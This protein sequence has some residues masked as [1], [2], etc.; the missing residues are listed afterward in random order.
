MF[1]VRKAEIED[2]PAVAEIHVNTWKYSYKGIIDDSLLDKLSYENSAKNNAKLLEVKNIYIFVACFN[3]QIVGFIV[4]ST[5]SRDAIFKEYA[6][7]FGLYILPDY[8]RQGI[9]KLLFNKAVE[10]FKINR[11]RAFMLWAL[12]DNKDKVFYQ[13]MGGTIVKESEHIIGG[14]P[15]K[16]EAWVWDKLC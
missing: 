16:T 4:F 3:N 1:L 14:Q 5:Q 8:Q 11:L 10:I 7:I 13:K 9:G 12:K 15:Y 2:M 6:E